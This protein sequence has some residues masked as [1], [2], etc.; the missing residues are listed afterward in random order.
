MV[1]ST[2]YLILK[3]HLHPI[4][5]FPTGRKVRYQVLLLSKACISLFIV[6]IHSLFLL[7]ST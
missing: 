4:G 5:F 7:A 6:V 3:T 1:S 2:L